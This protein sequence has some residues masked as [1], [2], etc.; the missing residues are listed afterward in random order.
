MSLPFFSSAFF[1]NITYKT[2]KVPTL[3]TVLSAGDLATTAEIYGSYTRS[4]VLEKGQVVQIVVDNDDTGKHPFHLHGHNVQVVWRSEEDAGFFADSNV[5]ESDFP[6]IPMRRDTVVLNPQGFMV[7]RFVADNP[8][9]L[10]QMEKRWGF[11]L[12]FW[13]SVFFLVHLVHAFLSSPPPLHLVSLPNNT[14][15]VSEERYY[16][17]VEGGPTT[18]HSHIQASGSSTATFSGTSTQASQRPSSRPP[19]SSN[20]S[21]STSP[22]TTM[23]PAQPP[24]PVR[25]RQ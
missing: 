19:S 15:P 9:T 7:L 16:T 8:G 20:N 12:C 3:Y 18:N 4:L 2:P 5:T 25:P 13:P 22:R 21:P 6:Q 14:N 17:A 10:C 1:N 11:F 23:R 24:A